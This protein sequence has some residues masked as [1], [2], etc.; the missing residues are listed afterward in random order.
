[1]YDFHY[2]ETAMTTWAVLRQTWTAVNKVAEVKLAKVGLTPEKAAVLWAC[3]DYMGTLT[4]AEISRLVFR[5]NQT[6]AG[7]LNRMEKEGLVKRIPKRK[8]RPF[9]EVKITEKGRKL[10]DPG[11]E[12]LKKV[13]R[14]LVA[15]VSPEEQEVLQATLR[16]LRNRMLDELHMEIKKPPAYDPE[17]PIPLSW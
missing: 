13:I 6:I 12:V 11:I 7:L 10:T 9:T 1:M 17:K 15:D 4:P 5:E 8:G 16:K 2:A 3:R 14:G